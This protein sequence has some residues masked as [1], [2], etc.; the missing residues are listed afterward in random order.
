MIDPGRVGTLFI[1]GPERVLRARD[2]V[3]TLGFKAPID[4]A[5]LA[6]SHDALVA[7]FEALRVSLVR[8]GD[9]FRWS[10]RREGDEA[11]LTTL[12]YEQRGERTLVVRFD[13]AVAN[14]GGALFFIDAWLRLYAGETIPDAMLAPAPSKSWL[15]RFTRAIAR[16]FF[17]LAY[18]VTFVLRAG[19]RAGSE[20]VDL[21]RGRAVDE[22]T[23]GYATRTWRFSRDET[24]RIV[25][26]ARRDGRSVTESLG[27]AAARALFA[28]QPDKRR[29][30][31][32]FPTDLGADIDG[33]SRTEPGN[34]TGSLI[35]QVFRDR[36]IET[37]IA[38]AWS[39]ARRR[40]PYGV[41]R[42]VAT[43]AKSERALEER[44]LAQAKTSLAARA[45]FE[46]F[47]CA[48][49][50]IGKITHDAILRH[51]ETISAH[52]MTQTIF[53]GAMTLHG[54]L[55]LEMCVANDLV[56]ATEAFRVGDAMHATLLARPAPCIDPD[57]R[58]SHPALTIGPVSERVIIHGR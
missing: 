50:S 32:S 19:R 6:A 21:S 22:H 41:A 20:T 40:V 4:T 31:L 55:S 54:R 16:L 26:E 53:I 39:A 7:R 42:L 43:F 56:D 25:D 10:S 38:R 5:R 49:S 3:L 37:Q 23:R 33:F 47:S 34:Y 12:T 14:G 27:A 13:H 51:I 44:F 58:G 18:V 17:T 9:R 29:V 45:P 1:R 30:L 11:P 57:R 52:G 2:M 15:V 8:D 24:A 35:V 48:V 28:A 36:R 46:N